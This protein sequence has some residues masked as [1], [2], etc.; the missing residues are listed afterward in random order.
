MKGETW[1]VLIFDRRSEQNNVKTLNLWR[2][3]VR[4]RAHNLN[5]EVDKFKSALA[6]YIFTTLSTYDKWNF[7]PQ[8]SSIFHFDRAS[9]GR[10]AHLLGVK[11][12]SN[13]S[14]SRSSRL[15]SLDIWMLCLH[16]RTKP[17]LQL[18]YDF[19][20]YSRDLTEQDLFLK[21]W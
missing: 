14:L 18:H 21:S 17:F 1:H 13:K 15:M 16:N 2:C 4:I 8:I 9:D 7:K 5:F 20:I 19:H 12:K 3:F 10:M 11:H 6:Y